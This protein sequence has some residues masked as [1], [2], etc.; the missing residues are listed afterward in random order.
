MTNMN[1]CGVVLDINWSCSFNVRHSFFRKVFEK[2]K[3][4]NGKKNC[5]Y[6]I[7]FQVLFF[8]AP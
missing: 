4:Y 5:K 7:V 6:M 8:D 3:H 2:V 1:S